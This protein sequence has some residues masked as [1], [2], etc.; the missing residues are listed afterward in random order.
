MMCTYHDLDQNV[1]CKI[2]ENTAEKK[3]H[4]T[5]HITALMIHQNAITSTIQ[6]TPKNDQIVIP[7]F[8]R[9]SKRKKIQNKKE[10][11]YKLTFVLTLGWTLSKK[12]WC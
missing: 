11:K 5:K 9:S 1:K 10:R 4:D 3:L 2:K 7:I 12:S 6:K 8:W